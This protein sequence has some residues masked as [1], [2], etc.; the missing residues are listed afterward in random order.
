MNLRLTG[1]CKTL[2]H[3]NEG[4]KEKVRRENVKDDEGVEKLGDVTQQERMLTHSHEH[5]RCV[6]HPK[7]CIGQCFVSTNLGCFR[8][9]FHG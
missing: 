1:A 7:M 5:L 2:N 6:T 3:G 8:V 9:I 4:M